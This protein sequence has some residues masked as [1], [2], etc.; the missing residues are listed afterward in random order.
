[1][2]AQSN[3]HYGYG[4]G[5]DPNLST[6]TLARDYVALANTSSYSFE[7]LLPLFSSGAHRSHSHY[8]SSIFIV[9]TQCVGMR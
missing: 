5:T 7:Y 8:N 4:L 9:V 2:T 1:M 6:V 3:D